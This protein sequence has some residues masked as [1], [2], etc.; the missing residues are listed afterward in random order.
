MQ[1]AR[2]LSADPAIA[3]HHLKKALTSAREQQSKWFELQAAVELARLWRD[4]G[5]VR[6]AGALLRPTYSWFTEGFDTPNLIEAQSL[7]NELAAT[8]T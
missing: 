6:D 5:R 8:E 7:L 1:R 2:I 4:H 3:E